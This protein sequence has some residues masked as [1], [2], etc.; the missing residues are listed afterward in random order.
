MTELLVSVKCGFHSSSFGP[1][2]FVIL[3]HNNAS[4]KSL[5]KKICVCVKAKSGYQVKG[6]SF[7]FPEGKLLKAILWLLALT[8]CR[9]V[10]YSIISLPEFIR[11]IKL[12]K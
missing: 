7:Q 1:S 5:C 6:S 9:K 11:S 8:L 2:V 12:L 10:C 3:L 4:T